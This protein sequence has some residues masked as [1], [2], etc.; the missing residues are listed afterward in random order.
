M[1]NLPERDDRDYWLN[2]THPGLPPT[3]Y[4]WAPEDPSTLAGRPSVWDE[5]T[6]DL[7]VLP[8]A[9]KEPVTVRV[10]VVWALLAL[11]C[12]SGLVLL[13]APL[14]AWSTVF[15]LADMVFLAAL[16][17]LAALCP[18]ILPEQP[19]DPEDP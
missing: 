1:T 10:W 15:I 18:T 2:P 6:M 16:V 17:V 11:E 12:A 9:R 14:P 19:E 5:P 3:P 13:F 8:P 4:G 7:G